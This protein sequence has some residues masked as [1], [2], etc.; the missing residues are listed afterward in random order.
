VM[1]AK[2]FPAYGQQRWFICCFFFTKKFNHPSNTCEISVLFCFFAMRVFSRSFT[3][4]R[5]TVW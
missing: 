3:T 5:G 2:V 4:A 1:V